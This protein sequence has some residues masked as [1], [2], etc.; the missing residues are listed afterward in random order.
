MGPTIKL[1]TRRNMHDRE[2]KLHIG[3]ISAGREPEGERRE[4]V[5]TQHSWVKKQAVETRVRNDNK[6]V[7]ERI[8]GW[9]TTENACMSKKRGNDEKCV[10]R[11]GMWPFTTMIAPS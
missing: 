4:R 3:L 2:H 5:H 6:D 11:G 1:C 10:S 7:V 8:I 9:K